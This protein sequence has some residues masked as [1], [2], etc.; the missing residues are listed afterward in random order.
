METKQKF[1][2]SASPHIRTKNSTQLIMLDVIIALIPVLIAAVYIFGMQALI[3]TLATVA[4]C[5]ISEFLI[6]K[7]MKRPVRISD[8]SAVVTGMLLAFNM[9]STM[10][11]WMAVFG[12]VFAIVVVKELFGGIG[13]NFMNPALAARAVLLSSWPAEMGTFT[14]DGV[15]S[16]TPLSGKPFTEMN[17]F[18]G[19]IPGVM[20][21]VSKAAILI[22]ALYLLIKGVIKI[23]M[24]AIYIGT[25]AI[26]FLILGYDLEDTIVQL[27]AGG[28][29]LG[30]FFMLTD[31]SSSPT[32]NLAQIVY[33][34]GAGLLTVI[35]RVWGGYP[36]GVSYAILLMNVA[37]PLFDKLMRDKTFGRGVVKK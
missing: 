28:I 19:N 24:P 5:V 13:N 2:V 26:F 18:L 17:M 3:L 33:A 7:A 36:E 35:I 21:E 15:V 1:M 8:L 29:F 30:G 31:Y 10:P 9:P 25:I 22:G 32:S 37:A 20:G 27:L 23:K 14:L 6:Q 4:A 16:A 34:V 11:I 12:G